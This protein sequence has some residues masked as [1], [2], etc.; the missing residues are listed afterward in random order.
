VRDVGK[1]HEENF[2]N[3]FTYICLFIY[4]WKAQL[5]REFREANIYRSVP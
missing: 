1:E 4:L 3:S 5:R 2:K